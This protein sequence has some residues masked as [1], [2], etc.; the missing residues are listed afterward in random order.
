MATV[1]K[2]QFTYELVEDWAQ[3]PAGWTLGQTGIVTDGQDRVYLFHR[4]AHPLIV[5][6]QDGTFLTSWGDGVLTSAHGMCIDRQGNLYLPV[7][8]SH[9]VLKYSPAGNLLMTLGTWNQPSETGWS[10]NY[11]DPVKQA[12]GPFHRPSDVAISSTGEI[13]ISDGYGNARIHR[14]AADGALKKSWGAPGKTAPGEFHVP[15]GVWVHTDGR[16][17]VADRENNRIQIFSPEG[18]FLTQWRD[19]AR[20]CDLY[21]DRDEVVYVP[22]LD[23]LITLLTLDGQV[24]TRWTSPTTTGAGDGGHAVWVDSHGDIYINQNQEGRRLLKYRRCGDVA[25]RHGVRGA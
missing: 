22:E 5:L 7:I 25:G 9:V 10:G 20:P 6:E 21:I 1:G 4:G 13:Y 3:L 16:V 8:N 19:L 2:G 11:R 14:F 12:A 15:H 18:E 17:L 23:G 24:L